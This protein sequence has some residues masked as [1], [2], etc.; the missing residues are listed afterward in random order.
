MKKYYAIF[1]FLLILSSCNKKEKKEEV[2]PKPEVIEVPKEVVEEV[3]EAEPQ[4]LFT[5]QIGALKNANSTMEN[6][7][8]VKVFD[9]NGYTKYRVG[10]LSTYQEARKLRNQLLSKYP[11]AF[12]Q[13]VK[14][15]KP[16]NIKDALE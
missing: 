16:I 3:K 6:V 5:V 13:A 2:I 11:G 7:D 15:D 9:E 1:A 14:G 8:G 4:L 12:V 10:F